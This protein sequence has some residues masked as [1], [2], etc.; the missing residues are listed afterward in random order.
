MEI[1][2]RIQVNKHLSLSSPVSV[3]KF[4]ERKQSRFDVKYEWKF[5]VKKV[6]SVSA[7]SEVQTMNKL[8]RRRNESING[9]ETRATEIEK[10]SA[11]IKI[12]RIQYTIFFQDWFTDIVRCRTDLFT[13]SQSCQI[14]KGTIKITIF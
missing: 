8:Y 5:Q 6:R 12:D 11:I 9:V 7:V 4:E 14:K 2:A 13:S 1:I 3:C 10:V